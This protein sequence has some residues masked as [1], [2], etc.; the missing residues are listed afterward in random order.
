MTYTVRSIS[1]Q[2]VVKGLGLFG[3]FMLDISSLK[4]LHDMWYVVDDAIVLLVF[5]IKLLKSRLLLF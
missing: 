1:K 3:L 4:Y 5:E 2:K